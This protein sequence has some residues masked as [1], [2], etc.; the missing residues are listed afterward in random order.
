[1]GTALRAAE[2][3]GLPEKSLGRG[4]ILLLLENTTK[5]IQGM[6]ESWVKLEAPLQALRR[7]VEPALLRQDDTEFIVSLLRM[8]T[9]NHG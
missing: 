7:F 4:E 2:T 1:M 9:T 6:R 8:K 5:I 3:Q